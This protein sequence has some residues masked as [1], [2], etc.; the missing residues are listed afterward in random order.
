MIQKI[1]HTITSW[2]WVISYSKIEK[3]IHYRKEKPFEHAKLPDNE[4]IK[5]HFHRDNST[6]YHEEFIYEF[7]NVIV[8]SECGYILENFRRIHHTTCSTKNR[9]PSVSNYI[10]KKMRR[11]IIYE[12]ACIFDAHIGNNYFHFFSDVITK[13]WILKKYNLDRLPLFIGQDVYYSTIFQFLISNSTISQYNWHVLDNQHLYTITKQLFVCKPMSYDITLWLQTLSLFKLPVLQNRR[14]F[15]YRNKNTSR[16]LYNTE[17]I[18][19]ILKQYGF[20]SIDT[21]NLPIREQIR[22]FAES[23]II[24]GVHGAGLTNMMFACHNQPT[25]IEIIPENR[26]ACQFYWMSTMFQFNYFPILGS[27]IIQNEFSVDT[28]ELEQTILKII[29]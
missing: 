13:L 25:I 22:Y 2:F 8:E 10:S 23:N 9:L 14:I 1:K 29:T 21:S 7:K 5:K 3:C 15:V 16:Y 4:T 18:S 26:I 20:E 12:S 17:T 6:H 19:K 11:K 27:S 24:I 28:N